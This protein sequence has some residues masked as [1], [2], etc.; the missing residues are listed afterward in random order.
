MAREVVECEV[1]RAVAVR[2]IRREAE[3]G[4]WRCEECGDLK[5]WCPRCGQGWVR[6]M[7]DPSDGGELHSCDECESTWP[8]GEPISGIGEDREGFLRR[9]LKP[10]SY[11]RLEVVREVEP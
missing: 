11:L 6:R 9:S 1:C 3:A 7:R 5:R 8:F 10:W 2:L 4:V